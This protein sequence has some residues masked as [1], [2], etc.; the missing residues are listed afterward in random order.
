MLGLKKK[1]KNATKLLKKKT[2]VKKLIKKNP[3]GFLHAC[4]GES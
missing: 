4:L 1:N 2:K 3:L